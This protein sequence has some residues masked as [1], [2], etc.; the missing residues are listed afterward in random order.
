MTIDLRDV[1][2]SGR[3]TAISGSLGIGELDVD[4]PANV[5]VD[6]RA[7]VGAGATELFGHEENGLTQDNHVIAGERRPGV[8]RLELR[9]GAGAIKVHRW[10]PNGALLPA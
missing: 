6:V 3:V 1:P 7:H 5:R 4:V 9:V 8:L 2:L 10:G